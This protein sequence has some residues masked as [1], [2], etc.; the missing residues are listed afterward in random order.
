MKNPHLIK[1]KVV[2]DVGCGTGIL[3]MF[4]AKAGAKHVYAIEYVFSRVRVLLS[5][6]AY[7]LVAFV[8]V[9]LS[10]GLVYV[11][12]RFGVVYVLATSVFVSVRVCVLYCL[13]LCAVVHLSVLSSMCSQ[14]NSYMEK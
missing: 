3:A 4:A 5:M 10:F 1:D 7:V 12:L 14:I 2:L 6:S 11:C 13:C 8:Y 9:C